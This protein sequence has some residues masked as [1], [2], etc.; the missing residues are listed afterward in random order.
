M[1]IRYG[2]IYS[3]RYLEKYIKLLERISFGI[4][5]VLFRNDIDSCRIIYKNYDKVSC[6]VKQLVLNCIENNTIIQM[7]LETTRE[8]ISRR[9][10]AKSV[11][12]QEKICIHFWLVSL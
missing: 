3:K 7:L 12:F 4:I 8:H 5:K 11:L 10:F 9:L 2:F 6:L 1:L